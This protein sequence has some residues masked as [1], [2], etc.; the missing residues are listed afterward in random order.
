ML[1]VAQRLAMLQSSGKVGPFEG[2]PIAVAQ[3]RAEIDRL[4][5][6]DITDYS[7]IKRFR[8]RKE[9]ERYIAV[10]DFETDP[11][12]NETE[13]E[14]QPFMA[15]LY[16]DEFAPI[17]IWEEDN[18]RFIAAVLDA[19]NTLPMPYTI[20]AHNGGKF[21]YMFLIKRLRGQVKFK[22]RS[23]MT[24]K[25]GA[26]DL[27]DSLHIIPEKLAN[28]KK[29][30]F[31]YDKNLPQNRFRYRD[32]ITRYCINDCKYALQVI[33]KFIADNGLKLSIGQAALSG[34]QKSHTFVRLG[35]HLDGK[36]RGVNTDYTSREHYGK[37]NGEGFFFG[38]RVEC[39]G[40]R[41]HFQGPFKLYDVNSMYPY[42]MAHM[43]H[44][45][46]GSYEFQSGSPNDNTC[47]VRLRCR[48]YGALVSREKDGGITAGKEYGEFFTT[49]HE[50]NAALACDLIDDI[51]IIQCVDCD[52]YSNFAE[53][54]VPMYERRQET[55]RQLHDLAMRGITSGDEYDAIKLED[56]CLKFYL[57]NAY[58]K[59]AQNPRKFRERYITDAGDYP[60]SGSGWNDVFSSGEHKFTIWEKG[61]ETW[62]D[63][64]GKYE[65][66]GKLRFYNV[67]TGASITGAARSVLMR[68]LHVSAN[69]IYCDTDS[70]IC[71]HLGDGALISDTQLG[72]WKIEKEFDEV[73]IVGKKQYAAKVTG[74]KEKDK[75]RIVIKNKGAEGVTWREMEKMLLGEIIEKVATGP[76]I[77]RTMDQYYMRRNI[78][79]TAPMHVSLFRQF[80]DL[81]ALKG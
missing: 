68:A 81:R 48:N 58:G 30:Q 72:A 40:G 43:Q 77:T 42:V 46:G 56:M 17:V 22:G 10:L 39:I 3:A 29:D 54:V 34:L 37:S 7:A 70:I 71:N 44:P 26:H 65:R 57:N 5:P 8:K 31:D 62:N 60:E 53:F 61:K 38:G 52:T 14:I 19:I 27:R 51:D 6:E 21:D 45:V 64:D 41:G 1:S 47:F 24:A 69:P 78:R 50:Y 80:H 20:Y 25:I 67:G 76:T 11:F 28:W 35:E 13:A 73:L 18:E 79:A 15:V 75:K 2:V 59:F 16:S 66:E 4:I 55:K 23:L 74:L 33:K 49:I 9:K 32:E 36:L 63:K 12:D